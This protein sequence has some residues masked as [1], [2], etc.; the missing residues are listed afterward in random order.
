MIVG[1]SGNVNEYYY[2]IIINLI[3]II[4]IAVHCYSYLILI[5]VTDWSDLVPGVH[6][7]M[8]MSTPQWQATSIHILQVGARMFHVFQ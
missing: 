8:C 3:I 2:Y 5:P 1:N 6:H 4:T 7:Q